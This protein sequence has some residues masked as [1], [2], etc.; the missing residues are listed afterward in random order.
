[1]TGHYTSLYEGDL[2]AYVGDALDG[3]EP[4]QGRI[5][6]FASSRDAHVMWTTGSRVNQIDVINV[7]D[8]MPVA[9]VASLES[10]KLTATS[11]RHVYNVEGE[12]GVLNYLSSTAQ[13]VTWPDIA[14]E[15]LEFVTGKLKADASMEL[16]WEQL[17]P[18][19]V[20]KVAALAATVLLRDSFGPED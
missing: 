2:V 5:M 1:M 17:E 19:Q 6:A 18:E 10:A 15:V 13:L 16:C 9:S 7:Y 3:I 20:S 4:A 14:A 12:T 11:V 8:L